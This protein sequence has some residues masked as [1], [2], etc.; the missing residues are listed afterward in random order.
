[1]KIGLVGDPHG[2]WEELLPYTMRIEEDPTWQLETLI[3]LGDAEASVNPG[4]MLN[5]TK[6]GTTVAIIEGNHDVDINYYS[7]PSKKMWGGEV[8]ILDDKVVH[9]RRSQVYTL[10]SSKILAMGGALSEPQMLGYPISGE[11]IELAVNNVTRAKGVKYVV[12][13][14]APLAALPS[15][16]NNLEKV[17]KTSFKLDSL[18]KY[19]EFDAWFF[20]HYHDTWDKE[21]YHALGKLDIKILEA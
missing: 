10:G 11:D 19:I 9:L 2:K 5:L 16:F 7:L 3:V 6:D 1:M 17:G 20:G 12:S 21:R 15:R 14:D 4:D 18:R 8:G 13:H